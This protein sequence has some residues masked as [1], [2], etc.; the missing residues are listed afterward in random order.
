MSGNVQ[1]LAQSTLLEPSTAAAAEDLDG[2]PRGARLQ[3]P[4][5]A[6]VRCCGHN[7]FPCA[8]D[9]LRLKAPKVPYFLC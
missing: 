4:T 8:A 3:Y 7:F 9:L 1:I 6:D 2:A 5:A